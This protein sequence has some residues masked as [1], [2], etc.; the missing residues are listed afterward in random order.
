M[1]SLSINQSGHSICSFFWSQKELCAQD[2]LKWDHLFRYLKMAVNTYLQPP[3]FEIAD[4]SN[5]PEESEPG[6]Q[7]DF[8]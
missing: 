6:A 4:F 1:V 2:L 5:L 3:K 8:T 7:S